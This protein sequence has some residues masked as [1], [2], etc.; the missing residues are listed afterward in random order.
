MLVEERRQKVLELV[1]TR[2][3]IALSDLRSTLEFSESTIRRDLEF[4][5]QQGV[6]KRTH[7]GA[8]YT[9]EQLVMPALDERSATALDEKR[10]I[11]RTA[12]QGGSYIVTFDASLLDEKLSRIVEKMGKTAK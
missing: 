1:K 7:G 10:Q 12:R 11:A 2:G 8:I 6:V 9:G 4:W 5:D 3:F